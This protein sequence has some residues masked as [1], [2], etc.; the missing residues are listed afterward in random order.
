MSF[1]VNRPETIVRMECQMF[2]DFC[3]SVSQLQEQFKRYERSGTLSHPALSELLGEMTNRGPLWR[4]KDACHILYSD[5]KHLDDQLLDRTIGS[6]FHEAIK[7]MEATYQSQ[8]Y[9][10]ACKI[11]ANQIKAITPKTKQVGPENQNNQLFN[12]QKSLAGSSYSQPNTPTN[13]G[14]KEDLNCSFSQKDW[15]LLADATEDLLT[16]LEDSTGDVKR[17][18]KRLQS[19]LDT[20]RPLLCLCFNGKASN[21]MLSKYLQRRANLI[22]KVMGSYYENFVHSLEQAPNYHAVA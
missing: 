3:A 15:A 9:A 6:I 20:C 16:V 8:H 22:K 14:L 12:E 19:L 7:L 17:C 18:I 21:S 1:K 10:N 13:I 11:Y 4:L 2:R 5:S